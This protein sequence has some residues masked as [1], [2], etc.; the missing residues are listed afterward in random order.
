M[1]DLE[2][3]AARRLAA[4]GQINEALA[5]ADL[6]ARRIT[7]ADRQLAAVQR[8]MDDAWSALKERHTV[9]RLELERK[10]T[11]ELRAV[12]RDRDEELQLLRSE[13][14]TAEA[15]HRKALDRYA[16][17]RARLSKLLPDGASEPAAKTNGGGPIPYPV[18]AEG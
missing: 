14:G 2:R 8:S 6:A 18:R 3:N 5:D 15:L 1:A 17:A 9:E 7:D 10:H 16:E 4:A 11:E 13:R 12:G